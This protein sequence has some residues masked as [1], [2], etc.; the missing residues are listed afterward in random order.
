[1]SLSLPGSLVP[2]EWLASHLDDPTLVSLDD[3]FKLLGVRTVAA[4]VFAARRI[5]NA[6]FFDIDATAE[7][8][9]TNDNIVV[10]YNMHGLKSGDTPVETGGR[11]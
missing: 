10:A 8:V 1:M 11:T 5:T 7:L 9:I 2:T 6:R 3:P 4:E